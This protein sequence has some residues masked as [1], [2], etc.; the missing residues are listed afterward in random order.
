MQHAQAGSA[1]PLHPRHEVSPPHR[2]PRVSDSRTLSVVRRV[3][4]SS[5]VWSSSSSRMLLCRLR[6]ALKPSPTETAISELYQLS[7]NHGF[8]YGLY[9]ALCTLRLP[10]PPVRCTQ[11]GSPKFFDSATDATLDMGGWLDLTQQG[12]SPCKT[13]QASP[14]A[15]TIRFSVAQVLWYKNLNFR[16]PLKIIPVW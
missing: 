14:G 10:C 7:G 4:S 13:H 6:C 8:P 9:D 15:L 3:P 2:R 1:S 5:I 12:L 16:Y 11:T